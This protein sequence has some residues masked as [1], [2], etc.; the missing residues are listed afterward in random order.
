MK[1]LKQFFEEGLTK[2]EFQDYYVVIK[3]NVEEWLKQKDTE[4][5]GGE[6]PATEFKN[7]LLEELEEK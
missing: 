4:D 7:E 3:N 1:T 2:E 5:F 6:M